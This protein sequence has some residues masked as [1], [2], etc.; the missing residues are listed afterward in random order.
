MRAPLRTLDKARYVGFDVAGRGGMGLVYVALDTELN[1]RV[2]FKMIQPESGSKARAATTP[3]SPLAATRPPRDTPASQAFEELKARFLQEA[4]VT[5]GMEHPGI[6]PVYELG[7]TP[8]GIPYYTM[9]FVRGARTLKDAIDE[10]RSMPVEDRLQLL[11]PFLK[12]CDAVAYAHS[13]GV[14]HRDLKPENVALGEFGEAVVLDWGLAKLQGRDDLVASRWQERVREFRQAGDLRTIAAALGTP[15]Y[16]SPEAAIGRVEEVDQQSDLYSLGVVLYEILTG[17]QPYH[18]TTYPD[19][20]DQVSREDPPEASRIDEEVPSRLSALAAR[21]LARDRPKRP[22]DVAAVARAIRSWQAASAIESEIEG[23]LRDAKAAI[24][25][26]KAE[27]GDNRLRQVDRAAAFLQQV[28]SRRPH[29]H[30]LRHLLAQ[31]V[32][33]RNTAIQE[34]ERASGRR[35]LRRVGIAALALAV[36]AALLVIALVNSERKR[37]LRLA[38]ARKVRQLEDEANALLPRQPDLREQIGEWTTRANALRER[39][40]DH[41]VA[42][43]DLRREAT[44]RTAGGEWEFD[45]ENLGWQHGMLQDLVLQL[46][47]LGDPEAPV[48]RRMALLRRRAE[49]VDDPRWPEAVERVRTNSKYAGHSIGRQEGL[50]PLGPD[51]DSKLEEFAYVASGSVPTRGPSRD[52]AYEPDTAI[53]LVLIPGGTFTL[54][55][56]GTDPSSPFYD[57]HTPEDHPSKRDV[58]LS[59][60]FIAKHECTQAQWAAL[61]GGLKPSAFQGQSGLYDRRPVESVAWLDCENVLGRHGL[62]LPTEAEWEHAARGEATTPFW[63]GEKP[64]DCLKIAGW[65]QEN[66]GGTT[67]AVGGLKGNAFG[68]YDVHGNVWEWCEF[69]DGLLPSDKM[70]LRGGS[71]LDGV[72]THGRLTA[73]GDAKVLRHQIHVGL[74]PAMSVRG[75]N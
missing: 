14:I 60:Y 74:R 66:S 4:W 15:G 21:C 58:S 73:R 51:P 6:V 67:H 25:A 38:D 62:R 50:V 27:E 63:S 33:L 28:E 23:H 57:R 72:E 42:L 54:G 40:S 35:L 30:G 12:L 2:A 69:V 13:R 20:L 34:R 26:A 5:G 65:H 3:S 24:A 7:Q 8:N 37:V 19:F 41:R 71:F 29:Q 1:R 52:L 9:K 56:Q 43:Q 59:A 61:T 47:A 17:K 46:E 68:L 31:T 45:D 44:S 75:E 49:A 16:M 64:E 70:A 32:E 22:K 11:E 39:L 36:V 55:A 48:Q 10:V 18:F 53:V